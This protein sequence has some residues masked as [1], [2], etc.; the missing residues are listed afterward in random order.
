MTMEDELISA[1]L[2][3]E[4]VAMDLASQHVAR[5]APFRK[6]PVEVPLRLISDYRKILAG[7]KLTGDDISLIV[8]R[9]LKLAIEKLRGLTL[10]MEHL[11]SVRLAVLIHVAVLVG[12]EKLEKMG[13]LWRALRE[14]RYE[15]AADA[16]LRSEWPIVVAGDPATDDKDRVIELLRM[17]RS[18]ELPF[19]PSR[20]TH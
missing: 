13:D 16:L 12:V 10:Q 5:F 7:G 6:L 18:G 11:N 15:D 8:R 20:R 3:K 19:P 4:D 2:A 14:R 17:M 1:A 9:D